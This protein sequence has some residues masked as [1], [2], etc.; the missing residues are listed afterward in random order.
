MGLD[1]GTPPGLWE[2]IRSIA[3][4][5]VV[6]FARSGFLRNASISEGGLTIKGGFL[7]LLAQATGGTELF[8]IGPVTPNAADGS[9][10][11]G[12]RVRRAD[13]TSVLLLRDAFP[14]D[15]GGVL[16]QA[17]NW[18]DRGGNV[19]LAD[20]TNSG[21]GIA[22][23]YIPGVFYQARSG[24]WPTTTSTTFETVYRMRLPKQ[25]PRLL[26]RAWGV[27]DTAEGVGEL[28]VMVNGTQLGSTV[29]TAY[30]TVTEY[31]FGPTA[32]D[33]AHLSTLVVEIQARLASGTGGVQCAP[34][35]AQGQQS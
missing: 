4:E 15:D 31:L 28:R 7:R 2:R 22:R 30:G 9:P 21:Q 10:Q 24:D 34:S 20:D 25:Q 5:E 6:K 12:W 26:L 14:T 11:Q 1:A 32:V 8:Y 27:S 23:P 19:V 33:G 17:L 29:T 16:N 35:Q 18:Y 3:A 13:G